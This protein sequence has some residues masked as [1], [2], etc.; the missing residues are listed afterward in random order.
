MNKYSTL[1]LSSTLLLASLA[2]GP[3][4]AAQN[5]KQSTQ[6]I[7]ANQL[8]EEISLDNFE[9]TTTGSETTTASQLSQ[10]VT[11]QQHENTL[12]IFYQR[13]VP[14]QGLK[15]D[16]AIWSNDNGQDDVRWIQAQDYQTD[17]PLQDF[18]TGQYTL[19]AY[20][21]IQGQIIFLQEISLNITRPKPTITTN[22]SEPGILDVTV[23]HITPDTKEVLLPT[24][25][26]VKG[27][28]DLKWYS[29]QQQANGSYTVRI[30]LKD[31][32]FNTGDYS[33]HLYTKDSSGKMT[34]VTG[35]SSTVGQSDVP[36]NPKPALAIENLEAGKGKYQV[37]I[38]ETATSKPIQSVQVATWSMD[39]QANLKWRTATLTNGKYRVAVDFQEHKQH[40]GSYQ[41]H[42]YVTYTDGSRVGYPLDIVD[43]TTARL[44]LVFNSKLSSV[45][46]I[47]ATLS[48]VYDSQAV[49]FAVW[50]DENGQDDLRWYD[51]SKSADK[52]F[53]RAIPLA[54]HKGIGKYHV[55]AYQ[56]GRGLGAFSM[57][58]SH[59]HRYSEPN[60]YPIGQCTWG[61]KEAAPWIQNYWGNAKQWLD[62]ARRAG[63][64]TGT[65]PQIGA[66]AVWTASYYGHVA[67]VTEVSGTNRIRVKE[68]NYAG[69]MTVGDYRG[70]FN[71]LTNGV[72]AYI[73]PS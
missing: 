71:P 16:Y 46:T 4:V 62:A 29:A 5:T 18:K 56:N 53:S 9:P 44:P 55:H 50:S 17:I 47:Q 48:N 26:T 51:T 14:Q 30:F 42:V 49:Q 21:T 22:I 34:F 52:S 19:H 35:I 39:K 54:N 70:W 43:L 6:T 72:T 28:D 33:T 57:E 45:G 36:A 32:Q 59:H 25:S 20:I 2:S 3:L 11:F 69:N 73:Y 7:E 1:L 37:T 41:N 68:S 24:W 10:N 38:Q 64:R 15:I 40:S 13:S 61:A 8:T 58:V 31:H 23:Q 66:V 67:V 63:F 60:T 27:Q 65:T 12:S